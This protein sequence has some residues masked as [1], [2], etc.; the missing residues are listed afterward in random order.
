[1]RSSVT[2]AAII[3]VLAL[4]MGSVTSRAA[5]GQMIQGRVR[6]AMNGRALEGA[7]VSLVREGGGPAIGAFTD[8]GGAYR[9]R[10][11]VGGP[12]RLHVKRIGYQPYTSG[13][14]DVVLGTVMAH[15][16]VALTPRP[17]IM[18][19]VNVS[20]DRRCASGFRRGGEVVSLWEDVRVALE[21]TVFTAEEQRF[22]LSYVTYERTLDRQLREQKRS[23]RTHAA[24][25]AMVFASIP[26]EQ[27]AE[28]GY[29]FRSGDEF[30]YR[31][32]DAHVLLSE[33]FLETHCFRA[34]PKHETDT[35]LVGLAFEPVRRGDRI[36]VR[37][38][39]WLDRSTRELEAIDFTYVGLNPDIPVQNLG[40]RVE[41]EQLPSGRW[42]VDRWWI[43]MPLIATRPAPPRGGR[44]TLAEVL[45]GYQEVGGAVFDIMTA[46]AAD[47]LLTARPRIVGTIRDSSARRWLADAIVTTV[48]SSRSAR[49]DSAGAFDLIVTT[50]GT[51]TL[52]AHHPRLDSLGFPKWT[53]EIEAD[54]ALVR[55]VT[56]AVPTLSSLLARHCGDSAPTAGETVLLGRVH[57]GTRAVQAARVRVTWT[58]T[59]I[60]ASGLARAER[61][62][63]AVTDEHG[64]FAI[65]GVPPET[66]LTV[67]AAADGHASRSMSIR[68]DGAQPW[69]TLDV[70]ISRREPPP[71]D[72]QRSRRSDASMSRSFRA[73]STT[74]MK[75]AR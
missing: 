74:R 53:W 21:A 22:G 59:V 25:G 65:C 9:L 40:G 57:D 56:L 39:L 61:E 19:T 26:A 54:T 6:D 2:R 47:T 49:T 18:A 71:P 67:A 38:V 32:L 52:V 28:E 45:A 5:T 50:P 24:R 30:L 73:A 62:R 33:S 10:P 46:A 4:G 75:S 12:Q 64:R 70:S 3:T 58:V 20:G 8:S 29:V 27:L 14:I 34:A 72:L 51:L 31:G 13:I 43:R 69:A 36:E 41:F 42:M 15:P 37:G 11:T 66:P 48:D 16:E 17:Q 63:S 68:T 7:V 44:V 1:M 60:G 35:S 23:E 55:N